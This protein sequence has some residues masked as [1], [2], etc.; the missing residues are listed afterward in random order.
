MNRSD[1]NGADWQTAVAAGFTVAIVGLMILATL[2][3]SGPLFVAAGVATTTVATAANAIVAS[4]LTV[5]GGSI[6][7]A[8]AEHS[9]GHCSTQNSNRRTSSNQMQEQVNRGKA[10]K[11]VDRV[12]SG[13]PNIPNSK[14]HIHFKDGTALNYDGTPS[15]IGN[16]FPCIT[17]AIRDWILSNNWCLPE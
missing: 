5:A 1:H 13:N 8:A 15:H 6:L 2:P 10:P 4:G 3:F 9:K 11:E 7:V 17:K 12:D 16:G 14:D